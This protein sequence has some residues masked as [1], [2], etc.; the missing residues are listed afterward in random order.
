MNLH[1]E[2]DIQ[3]FNKGS[4]HL[5]K[6]VYY[7]TRVYFRAIISKLKGHSVVRPLRKT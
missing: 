1:N 7:Q 2:T 5:I 3:Y 6:F 4:Y